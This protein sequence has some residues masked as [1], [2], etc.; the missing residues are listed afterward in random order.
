[1]FS[2]IGS[3]ER[4]L[5]IVETHLEYEVV[6]GEENTNLRGISYKVFK[7]FPLSELDTAKAE[8]DELQADGEEDRTSQSHFYKDWADSDYT[9]STFQLF[10]AQQYKEGQILDSPIPPNSELVYSPDEDDE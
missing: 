10:S 8:V 1:M 3:S 4:E 7:V 9:H 6:F 5:I 2:A